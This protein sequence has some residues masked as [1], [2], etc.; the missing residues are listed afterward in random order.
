MRSVVLRVILLIV[1]SVIVGVVGLLGLFEASNY[2]ERLS[3]VVPVHGGI[4]LVL[5]SMGAVVGLRWRR[6]VGTG[7]EF[8][9]S[10]LLG[11]GLMGLAGFGL[12]FDRADWVLS[13]WPFGIGLL[14]VGVSV[15]SKP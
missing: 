5:V 7:L 9:L 14:L 15:A 8:G 13:I 12:V 10:V 6:G 1:L 3:F 11:I 4:V 2:P